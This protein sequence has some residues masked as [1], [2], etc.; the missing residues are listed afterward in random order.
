MEEDAE[1]GNQEDRYKDFDIMRG[2]LVHDISSPLTAVMYGSEILKEGCS[3]YAD[4][5]D[6]ISVESSKLKDITKIFSKGTCSAPGGKFLSRIS[7]MELESYKA[8]LKDQSIEAGEIAEEII[9][10][11]SLITS[12]ESSSIAEIILMGAKRVQEVARMTSMGE[13]S[14]SAI[15]RDLSDVDAYALVH[16]SANHYAHM[17]RTEEHSVTVNIHNDPMSTIYT[18]KKVLSGIINA[19]MANAY[20]YAL[21]QTSIEVGLRKKEDILELIVEDF[22]N[23]TFKRKSAGMGKG[24]GLRFIHGGVDRLDGEYIF[25]D[26]SQISNYEKIK[27]F[28]YGEGQTPLKDTKIYSTKITIPSVKKGL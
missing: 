27:Q 18:S 14:R 9:D 19:L 5:G 16:N 2:M 1:I 24:R 17:F 26:S 28:R 22:H 23:D 6:S 15:Q 11:C 25:S 8:L 13:L 3:P 12:P 10:Y 7:D 21:P 4:I 20:E